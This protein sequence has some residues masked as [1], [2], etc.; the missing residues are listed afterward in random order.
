MALTQSKGVDLTDALLAPLFVAASLVMGGLGT[1]SLDQPLSFSLSDVLYAASGVEI[2]YAFIASIVVLVIAWL[3]N[4]ARDTSDYSQEQL[5]IIGAM[6]L[7]NFAAVLV[8]PVAAAMDTYWYAGGL[9]VMIN[10]AGYYLI[11]YY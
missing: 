9:L 1:F 8:P 6:V 10:S 3:T 5:A 7:L 4:E 2:T 11:A